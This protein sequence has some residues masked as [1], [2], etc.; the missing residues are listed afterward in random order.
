MEGHV[1]GVVG[2]GRLKGPFRSGRANMEFFFCHKKIWLED[3]G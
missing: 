3:E 1:G 2:K